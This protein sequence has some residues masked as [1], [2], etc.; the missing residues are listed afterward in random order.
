MDVSATRRAAAR[1]MVTGTGTSAGAARSFLRAELDGVRFVAFERA[2]AAELN[3]ALR[4]TD[5]VVFV[6]GA[7]DP[8]NERQIAAV[9]EAARERGIL[10]AAV[11]VTAN[12]SSGPS[13]LLAALR[14]AADMVMILRDAGDVHAVVA[15]LR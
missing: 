8:A 4:E 12:R 2:D 10:L 6:A 7:T 15:A 9:A 3:A 1:L 14:D 11:V 13:P 5:I